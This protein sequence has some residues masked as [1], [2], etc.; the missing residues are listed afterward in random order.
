[1]NFVHPDTCLD[2]YKKRR[3]DFMQFARKKWPDLRE[4]VPMVKQ[5]VDINSPYDSRERLNNLLRGL[6]G[7]NRH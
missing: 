4:R 3:A 7:D 5:W 6:F 1:M 2:D